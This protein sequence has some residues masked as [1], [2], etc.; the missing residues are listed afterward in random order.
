MAVDEFYAAAT[1]ADVLRSQKEL[2][3]PGFSAGGCPP[4]GYRREPIVIGALY[5]G[6]PLTRVRWV[7][8]PETAP[9]VVQAFQM[10]AEGATYDEIVAARSQPAG[11]RIRVAP[12]VGLEPTTKR[13]TAARSTTELRRSEDAGHRAMPGPHA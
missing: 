12:A 10:A 6:T 9:K 11:F 5:D 1:A 3:R 2:A 13:L 4:V 7:P 8:D